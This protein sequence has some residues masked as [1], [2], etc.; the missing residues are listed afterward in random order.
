MAHERIKEKSGQL[1]FSYGLRSISMDDVAHMCGMSKKSVYQYFEDKNALVSA[2]VH[3]LIKSHKR[4]LKICNDAAEDAIDEVI[5]QIEESF[6]IWA[7]I[8]PPFFYELEKFCPEA[9]HELKLYRLKMHDGIISNLEWGKREGIYRNNINTALIA[10]LRLHQ[11]T[12]LLQQNFVTTQQWSI[13]QSVIEL[14]DL[15]LHSIATEKGRERLYTI[16]RNDHN[17]KNKR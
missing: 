3:D 11:L 13:H 2:I 4:L 7:A 10:E 15:Y 14:T 5:K 8:R 9:W 17:K 6:N 12:N 1:F 16:L